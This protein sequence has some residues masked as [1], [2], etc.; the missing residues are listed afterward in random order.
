MINCKNCGAP[1][2]LNDAVC[3][4]C[5]TPNPEAQEH[6]RKLEALDNEFHQ[7]RNE[8]RDEVKKSRKGYGVL[9]ALVMVLL[10]NLILIPLHMASY[11]I[12]GKVRISEMSDKEIREKMDT[13]LKEGEFSELF[14]FANKYDLPYNEYGEYTR[15][16]YLASDYVYFIRNVTNYLYNPDV[17]SDPLVSACGNIID[18]KS[19]YK[20]YLRW[21]EDPDY[22]VY[23]EQLNK[24]FDAAAK[25][26][27][28]L[29][30]ED[31]QKAEGMTNSALLVRVNER[32]SNEDK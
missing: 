4:N 2:S 19:Q 30:D 25:E 18:F 6:L 14:L 9:V 31:L 1:L 11:E 21:A 15:I 20:S 5:G 3:P 27:L 26:Y 22:I 28:K 8:V 24:D 7:A 32:M 23:A 16:A 29:T 13:L 10:A 17:Y 12:A